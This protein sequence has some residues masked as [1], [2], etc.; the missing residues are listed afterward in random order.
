MAVQ[1]QRFKNKEMEHRMARVSVI[2]PT[3][4]RCEDV[5]R[6]LESL[7]KSTYRDFEIILVDNA[8]T[9][10]F[11]AVV[12]A[13]KENDIPL[14]YVRLEKNMMAAGGR[15]AGIHYASGEF[16]CFIDSDNIVD[17]DMLLHLVETMDEDKQI[18]MVG[19]LML[20]Y[21]KPDRIWFAGNDINMVT[22]KTT[23]WNK[24]QSMNS[25]HLDEIFETDH[26]PN[27]MMV[28]KSVQE[29]I[30]D[31]DESYY[32]MYEEADYAWRIRNAGYK[33]VVC[34]S[35]VTYHNCYLQEEIVDNEMRKLGCENAQRTYH[36][37]KNRG[38]FIRRY[39]PWYGKIAYFCCFRF[40][41][42]VIYCGIAIKNGRSD[43]AKAWWKGIWYRG[44]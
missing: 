3:F 16:L 10:S 31:F 39:A 44:K 30:G 28:R 27:L 7:C 36:F 34:A 21:K 13:W 41:F 43:I 9:E 20:Y 8:S 25:V 5:M 38:V 42:A 2:I 15:N 24:E 11:S 14:Q 29:Q 33:I 26:I 1:P 22:S 4:N 23:Y 6:L 17:S 32:I 12:D 35:A 37:S 19:P 18:G 40:V